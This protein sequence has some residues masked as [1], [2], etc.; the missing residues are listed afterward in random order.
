MSD[1]Y[2]LGVDS[3]T[4]ATKVIAFDEKGIPMAEGSKGYPLFYEQPGWVEQ[5][6]EDWWDA[7]KFGCQAVVSSTDV[8]PKRFVGMGITHQRFTFVPMDS[9][10]KPLRKAILWNDIRCSK[11]AEYAAQTVG[12]SRIF[13]RTGYPPGQW[14]LYK[15]LWL[16]NNE[17]DIYEKL[18]KIVLVQDYLIYRLTGKLV[19]LEGAC[20]MTGALDIANPTHWAMDVIR[21]LGVREDIW[22]D[23]I[24][25]GG[26]VAGHVTKQAA[27]ET[28][29]PEGLPVVTGAGDQPCGILGAGV[30]QPGELGINGGT[31]CTNELVSHGLPERKEVNYF[32]EISPS[33]DYI[34]E[35]YI[36]SG[37]SALMNW[38][39]NNFGFYEEEQARREKENVWNIIYGQASESPTGN[40]GM[41]VIPY[42]QGANGPYWDLQARGVI[43]GLHTEYGRPHFVRALIEGCA[44]ESRRQAELME[45]G[46]ATQVEQIKMYGGSARSDIWN[47]V[48]ADVLNKPLHVPKTA[49]TTALGA[50]ISAA[51]GCG[52]FNDFK[53]TVESMVSIEK[54]YTP[55]PENADRYNRFYREVYVQFYDA[56]QGFMHKIAE[57]NEAT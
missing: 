42:F 18:F 8:D 14:T 35:N 31:S 17:P 2:I 32:I 9:D 30:T 37:G 24:L 36:P 38:Y 45:Q 56:V 57:I 12:K 39:K 50:A 27:H 48:F 54:T 47:Q 46:T 53:K 23:T 19:T 4:S 25:P 29:L 22:I 43:F 41:M 1:Q 6:P 55:I 52:L 15:A 20:T 34:V 21:D 33:G 44:Y 3:S 26:S 7:F 51:V 40:R 16:K 49:E 5:N 28:G 10:M 11:E 13:E